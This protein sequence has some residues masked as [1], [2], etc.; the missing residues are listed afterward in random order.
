MK[1]CHKFAYQN[2][3]IP[4]KKFKIKKIKK[5]YKKIAKICSEP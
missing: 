1:L 2:K 5:R 3:K 4:L